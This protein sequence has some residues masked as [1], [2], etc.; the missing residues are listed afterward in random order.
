[1]GASIVVKLKNQKENWVDKA[2]PQPE[3]VRRAEDGRKA[4]NSLQTSAG[5]KRRSPRKDTSTTDGKRP[6]IG[7][8]E[9]KRSRR[10][11]DEAKDRDAKA[12]KDSSRDDR[13]AKEAKD[14]KP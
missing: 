14:T 4:K 8:Q 9:G 3:H 5:E 6:G 1:M 13:D 12:H 11:S 7:E 2:P 10:D